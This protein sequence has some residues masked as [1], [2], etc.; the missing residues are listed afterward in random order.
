M[1]M[2]T[3]QDMQGKSVS[4]LFTDYVKEPTDMEVDDEVPRE[5]YVIKYHCYSHLL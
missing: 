3:L 1:N 4:R 2:P 5:T